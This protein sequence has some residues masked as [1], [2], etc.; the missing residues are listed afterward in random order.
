[1]LGPPAPP[2]QGFLGKSGASLTLNGAPIR[3]RGYNYAWAGPVCGGASASSLETTFARIAANSKANVVRVG[4]FQTSVLGGLSF[5]ASDRYI[6][7][8]KKY[9]LRLIPVLAD[10]WGQCEN[11]GGAQPRQKY[12]P[13]YQTGFTASEALENGTGSSQPLSFREYAAAFARHYVN[14]PTIAWYQLVNE[15]DGRNFNGSC[16]ESG[17]AAAL[18]SFA[19]T[20]TEAMKLVDHNHMVDLG[21]VSW[22]GG[23][24]TSY[25][26]VNG[27]KVDVCDAY[28]D[29]SKG[30]EALPAAFKSHI[31]QCLAAG[32]PAFVGEAGICAYVDATGN[33]TTPTTATTLQNRANDFKAKI[34]AGLKAGLSG[35]MIWSTGKGCS[36]TE[37]SSK[38][39]VGSNNSSPTCAVPEVDPTETIL[40]GA[41]S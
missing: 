24:G 21:A 38:W 12:L 11:P 39:V 40:A 35:Y 34:E 7:Y 1:L 3:L 27:G 8:A 28:H 22:C 41:A 31:E 20:V 4:M 37:N 30:T 5:A 10:N 25:G 18:R 17:A 14:E 36:G 15:P 13:W 6:E 9:G 33:C 23:Q 19:D 32:K 29:Y 16:N 26:Y 2:A